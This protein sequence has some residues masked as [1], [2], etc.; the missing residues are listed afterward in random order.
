MF[1][2][3]D[4]GSWGQIIVGVVAIIVGVF[5]VIRWQVEKRKIGYQIKTNS[6]IRVDGVNSD[7]IEIKFKGT[8]VTTLTSFSI[9]IKNLGN[10]PI[11]RTD[12]EKPIEIVFN[13]KDTKILDI[14]TASSYPPRLKVTT[15]ILESDEGIAAI[16]E[17][18]LLN[19]REGFK[20]Q[21]VTSEFAGAKINAR[22]VGISGLNNID[23][24][25][26]PFKKIIENR[27]Y[28]I[29][30]TILPINMIFFLEELNS[31]SFFRGAVAD[32]ILFVVFM[33]I[34]TFLVW[35]MTFYEVEKMLEEKF[36]E[37]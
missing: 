20:L 34:N 5:V 25:K 11:L 19:S 3:I 10:R 21:F 6:I 16:I 29:I 9:A 4:Q 30:F 26:K 28:F 7:E 23:E 1:D 17:P 37:E 36:V 33:T 27:N 22:F 2:G 13:S 18:L 31:G 32:W 24:D 12:W 15:S 35:I 14:K 8:Q